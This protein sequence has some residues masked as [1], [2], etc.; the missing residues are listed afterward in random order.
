[1]TVITK[2]GNISSQ[3]SAPAQTAVIV[4][5]SDSTVVKFRSLWIGG[6]AGAAVDVAVIPLGGTVAVTFVAVPAGTL[7]PV[8]VSKVMDTN[9]SVSPNIVG[10]G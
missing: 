5:E 4:V 9:T 2:T 1:M 3:S 8:A 10:L 7:L 6:N